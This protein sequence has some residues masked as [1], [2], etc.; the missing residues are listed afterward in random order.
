MT[1]RITSARSVEE[2]RALGEAWSELGASDVNADPEVFLAM[3]ESQDDVLRPHVVLA[4]A[5]DA[6]ALLAARLQQTAIPVRLG[7]KQIYGP[8][9]RALTVVQGGVLGAA[10]GELAG[11][12]FEEAR[13]ALAAGEADV[14]RL[15]RLPVGSELH[16]LARERP[17]FATRGGGSDSS[18]RWRLRLPGS[19]DEILKAQSSRTRS[20]HRRYARKLEEQ[21]GDGLSFEVCRDPADLERV[22]RHAETVSVKT[23]Q[24][25]LGGGF[26][27][28]PSELRLVELGA[29]R[30]WLRAYLLSVDG[31]PRAFW[32]G[33]AYGRVFFTG[34]TGYD[35]SL[36][37]LRLGTYVL[38][39]MLED[40]CE[41][42]AVDVVD[43]G[44][45]D[46]EYKRHFGSESSLEEDVLVFA[47]SFRGVR[48]NLTRTMLVNVASAA[49]RVGGRVPALQ[50]VKRRWRSRLAS[51]RDR[52]SEASE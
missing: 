39:R 16:R 12:L 15:R 14:L 22:T 41:D 49:R 32:I 34:P 37:H 27:A 28:D 50:G 38:M 44:V 8:R 10:D 21:L 11:V 19:L 33:L 43:Y 31:E 7:Y 42:D 45:G 4:E 47:P 20:N 23:Y 48:V 40:L 5:N 36:G 51:G 3:L 30:G 46:A 29:E 6:R 52:G 17:S 35:P 25:R 9:L 1:A 18:L 13:A 2:V 26:A 24:H